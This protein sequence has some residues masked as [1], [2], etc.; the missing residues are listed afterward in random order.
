MI[1]A[2]TARLRL[3]WLTAEDAPFILELVNEPSWI[4]NI[5]DKGVKDLEGARRYIESGPQAMVERVGFGLNLV[6]LWDGTPAG[7][8]G[9]IKRDNLPDVD[10]GYAFLPAHCGKGYAREAVIATLSYGHRQFALARVIAITMPHNLRSA[11]L[12]QD[13]GFHRE[14]TIAFKPGEAEDLLFGIALPTQTGMY[15]P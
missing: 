11:K 15:I 5:G 8:C 3:R 9:L 7:L 12:L 10:V 2:E 1:V 13:V 6:E 4:A 14:G